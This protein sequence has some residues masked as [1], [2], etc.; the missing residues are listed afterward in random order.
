[1]NTVK[2]FSKG[3]P[4]VSIYSAK[5]DKCL[6]IQKHANTLVTDLLFNAQENL[7]TIESKRKRILEQSTNLVREVNL[8]T[9][10]QDVLS[11]KWSIK[12]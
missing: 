6:E 1:M 7:A 2:Q 10:V 11:Y 4:F 3:T 9:N 5:A 12:S 8:L